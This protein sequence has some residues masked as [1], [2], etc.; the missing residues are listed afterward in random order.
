MAERVAVFGYGSL[1]ARASIETTLGEPLAGIWPAELAGWRRGFT[2]AR[3]NEECEKT[4]AREDDG[5]IPEWVLGLNVDRAEG[6]SVNGAL[7]ELT[8]AGRD[9]LDVRELRYSQ[10]GVGDVIRADAP[11]FDRVY[12]YVARPEH[13]FPETPPGA[14]ILRSYAEA[15]EAAF[16]A[17][18]P[19]ELDRFRASTMVPDVEVIDGILVR[20]AIPPGNPRAW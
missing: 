20:D 5:H 16:D 8:P 11:E 18:G 6:A 10:V 2:Q 7:I 4:F 15:V 17:L 1:V 12:T 19:G 14:V 13:H 9:R 3:H